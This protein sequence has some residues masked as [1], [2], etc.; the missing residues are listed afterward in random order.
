M[1]TYQYIYNVSFQNVVEGDDFPSSTW[2]LNFK[3]AT[4]PYLYLAKFD[5][6]HISPTRDEGR[7][8]GMT[9]KRKSQTSLANVNFF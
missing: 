5:I 9:G 4:I 2:C 3:T 7:N 6:H 1:I 8:S